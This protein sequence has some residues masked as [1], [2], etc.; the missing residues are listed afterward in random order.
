M[1]RVLV[2]FSRNNK[3][4][5]AYSIFPEADVHPISLFDKNGYPTLLET[6]FTSLPTLLFLL[7][8]SVIITFS[9]KIHY[10]LMKCNTLIVPCIFEALN[11]DIICVIKFFLKHLTVGTMRVGNEI[12]FLPT[13]ITA[14]SFPVLSIESAAHEDC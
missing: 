5:Y 9:S 13:L 6:F 14:G 10:T 7:V 3:E 12:A 11:S 1:T 2:V 8:H 4:K